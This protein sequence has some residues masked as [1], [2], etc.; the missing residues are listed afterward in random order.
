MA[1][2]IRQGKAETVSQKNHSK[3]V[4]KGS[5]QIKNY[6]TKTYS[7]LVPIEIS[8]KASLAV[9]HSVLCHK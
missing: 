1:V 3:G 8:H 9:F 6:L 7:K 4:K 2:K 5:K